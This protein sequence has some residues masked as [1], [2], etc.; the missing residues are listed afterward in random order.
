MGSIVYFG[1]RVRDSLAA[2]DGA[3]DD[4]GFGALGELPPNQGRPPDVELGGA[5]R[6]RST[7]PKGNR[8]ANDGMLASD[9]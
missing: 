8:D 1:S 4:E 5:S 9:L 6:C 2:G 3:E 7:V